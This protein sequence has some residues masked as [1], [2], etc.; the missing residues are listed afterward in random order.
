MM[1]HIGQDLRQ[2]LRQLRSAPGVTVVALTALALGIGANSAIF[3]VVN[4]V[5]LSRLPV[6]EPERLVQL[7]HY[8]PARKVTSGV[9]QYA[10]AVA[11][12]RQVKSLESIGAMV[13]Q[14]MSLSTGADPERVI[15]GKADAAFLPMLG[16]PPVAGRLYSPEEDRPGGPKVVVLTFE[17]WGRRFGA[18]PGVI[19][20][21]VSLD[22]VSHHIIGVLPQGFRWVGRRPDAFVPAQLTGRRGAPGEALPV[23]GRLRAGVTR[24]QLNAELAVASAALDR[25]EPRHKGWTLVGGD[26]KEYIVADVRVTLWVLLGA[27]GLVVLMACANVANLLLARGAVRRREMAVR[28]ALGAHRRQLVRQLIVESLPLGFL[29]SALGLMA[30]WWSV[31]LLPL[32]E[33]ERV[34]R[35]AETRLDGTVLLYTLAVSAVVCVLF[36]V[37]PA[38]SLAKT[39]LNEAMRPGQGVRA[40][41]LRSALVAVEVALAVMLVAGAGLL[42]RT[43]FGLVSVQPGFRPDGLLTATIE[44]PR[45]RFKTPEDPV[46]FYAAIRSKLEALPGVR[47][48]CLTSSLP[49]GGNY[50]RGEFRFEGTDQRAPL[51][52]RAVDHFYLKTFEVRLVRGRF[53]E[54]SDRL[55]TEPVVVINEVT[56]RTYWPR[57]EPLGKRLSIGGKPL[58]VAGVIANIKHMDVSNGDENEVLLPWAQMPT[59]NVALALRVD[60][61]VYGDA[62]RLA[63]GLRRAVAEV[64]P[65]QAVAQIASMEHIMADR[66]S[67]RRLTMVLLLVFAGVALVLAAVGIHGVLSFSV[68]S[69][70]KEFGVRLAL[71]ATEGNVVRLVMRQAL[72]LAAFGALAGLALAAGLTRLVQAILFNVSAFDPRL[73]AAA[74]LVLFGVAAMS[75]WLPA[76]RAAKVEPSSALRHE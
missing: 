30:G 55:G 3:S 56:A 26:I 51:N 13:T 54:E 29:G 9:S 22:A 52:Y 40:G 72:A 42:I 59:V 38:L 60:G 71:G 67:P 2:G 50:F 41:R 4:Q 44:P 10:D 7:S 15:V 16:L 48:A 75:A 23:Y 1:S 43:F 11:W 24:E 8:L 35:L 68:Q 37:A 32:L 57:E 33:T 62:M 66:L 46:A 20:R 19:G 70:T 64:E 25:V 28:L 36:S 21:T 76:R 74:A 53:F 39:D 31:K 27:V 73:Y 47:A 18:D 49:L 65:N 61:A 5:L 45:A 12:R 17:L 63:P 6:R 69:R 58:T 34:P 14:A